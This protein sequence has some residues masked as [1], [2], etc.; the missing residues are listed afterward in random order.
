MVI[1]DFNDVSCKSERKGISEGNRQS[2]WMEFHQFVE[3]M[4]LV[5]VP[6]SGKKF[7]LFSADGRLMSRL[8]K[9]LLSSGLIGK[10]KVAGQWVGDKDISDHC[11]VSLHCSVNNWGPKPFRVN[12]CWLEHPDF[13]RFVENIWL[14][15][16]FDG[17]KAFVLKEKLKSLKDG[18]R[19]E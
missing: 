15:N 11:P 12:N 13:L 14:S 18:L 8:D 9:F 17:K 3:D 10:W 2:E 1:G 7:T 6:M 4:E 16:N 19:M 5:D